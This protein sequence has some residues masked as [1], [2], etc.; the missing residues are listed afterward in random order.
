M[1]VAPAKTNPLSQ[2]RTGNNPLRNRKTNNGAVRIRGSSRSARGASAIRKN[3]KV[4]HSEWLYREESAFT[5]LRKQQIPHDRT[6]RN[7]KL[8]GFHRL[9]VERPVAFGTAKTYILLAAYVVA[10]LDT[11]NPMPDSIAPPSMPLPMGVFDTGGL[12]AGIDPATIQ[13]LKQQGTGGSVSSDIIKAKGTSDA[14]HFGMVGGELN[15]DKLE[16]A[17]WAIMFGPSVSKEIRKNLSPLIEKRRKDVGDPNL[18]KENLDSPTPGQS[19]SDWLLAHKTS[20]NV[21][22]PS[23]GIPYYVL[24]VA[25]PEEV[26]F[27]FQYELDMY[28][29]VGRLWLQN[30]ADYEMY[31]Q[32]VVAYEDTQNKVSSARKMVI[33]APDYGG[34]DN[35]AGKLLCTNLATPLAATL[36][37]N[38]KFKIQS[39]IG[40]SA[41][42]DTLNNIFSGSDP[43][44][45]PALL[46]TG[47]HGLR[48]LATSKEL[49]DAQG[50]IVCDPWTDPPPD[51]SYYAA[52]DLPKETKVH[53]MVH[54]LFNCYGVGWP[55][56]DTY[57][58]QKKE[59]ISPVPMM[60][61]LPQALLGREN[62]ALAV[63]G[64]IDRA[65][66]CSYQVDGQPPQDQSFR[67]VLTK[68]M[69]G[70][71]LGSATDQFNMRWAALTIPLADTLQRMQTRRGL[72]QHAA[73]QWV[74]RDDARNY[75]LH[76]DPAVKLRVD[77]KDMPPLA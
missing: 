69:N 7:D 4:C 31:A 47:S 8:Y 49:A 29:A 67:D 61:R 68:I 10:C 54:F 77:R 46:F 21:V 23:M 40:T 13:D 73:N 38:E 5:A 33:F 2:R 36:G 34:Q 53:G 65:W 75:I 17:G 52:W 39:F 12:S 16:Q 14:A 6:V 37:K 59:A 44:G 28:W 32:S 27:E 58:Y 66:S 15:A 41:T 1:L 62:G 48:K 25:S 11:R 63:L 19:A 76:G 72:E 57:S 22:D 70:Y 45:T 24:I 3:S 55:K 42:K 9:F 74:I 50:A 60:A 43:D 51:T 30:D 71:R 18:F 64:H 20:L 35:G 26:S 56:N